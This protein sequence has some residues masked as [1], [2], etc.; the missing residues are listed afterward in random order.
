MKKKILLFV[1]GIVI[2]S[3]VITGSGTLSANRSKDNSDAS[4]LVRYI[5]QSAN[6]A[7]EEKIH[8]NIEDTNRHGFSSIS[9]EA[10]GDNFFKAYGEEEVVYSTDSSI[11]KVYI[12]MIV[13]RYTETKK[14]SLK[15][16]EK[17]L[18]YDREKF[19]QFMDEYLKELNTE[20]Q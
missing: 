2:T 6:A 11:Y 5:I 19:K 15:N 9:V 16:N 14:D 18:D 12:H 1:V 20:K 3:F 10:E 8:W 7:L 17:R 13:E 4:A